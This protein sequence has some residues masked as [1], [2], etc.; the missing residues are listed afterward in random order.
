MSGSWRWPL[1][2]LSEPSGLRVI[3]LCARSLVGRALTAMNWPR[4]GT[5]SS[6]LAIGTSFA[7]CP[8]VTRTFPS[9]RT[10]AQKSIRGV[11][12]FPVLVNAPL[13]GSYSSLET[14][15]LAVLPAI[16]T[17][18]SSGVCPPYALAA[19]TKE[20]IAKKKKTC[21]RK[22]KDQAPRARRESDLT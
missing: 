5:K 8:P 19:D 6:A 2:G 4:L 11:R 9:F 1:A 21:Q 14:S 12:I 15:I 20:T 17:L 3:D 22:P 18:P 16:D 10:V 13:F 7:S